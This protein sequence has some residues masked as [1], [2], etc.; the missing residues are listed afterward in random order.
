MEGE[1]KLEGLGVP[2]HPANMTWALDPASGD[3]VTVF[4]P[5]T[6][7]KRNYSVP[8]TEVCT[9]SSEDKIHKMRATYPALHRP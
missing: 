4:L 6:G 1:I 3:S 9:L 8:E 7:T 5:S 2:G